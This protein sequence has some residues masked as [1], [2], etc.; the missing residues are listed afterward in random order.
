[1]ADIQHKFS[2]VL[3]SMGE[4]TLV[5][6]PSSEPSPDLSNGYNAAVETFRSIE[7]PFL[8]GVRFSLSAR[9]LSPTEC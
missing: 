2:Q 4:V 6:R 3:V 8:K 5:D 7:Y 9:Q 1:M